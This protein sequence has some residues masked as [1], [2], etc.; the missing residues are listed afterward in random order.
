MGIRKE[1]MKDLFEAFRRVDQTKNRKIEGTGLGLPITKQLVEMMGGSIM[2]DS[3]YR[4]GSTFTIILEQKIIDAKPM[5]EKNFMVKKQKV[6]RE[7]YRQ[8]FEAPDAKVLVVD[9][10]E[11][12][13]MV[14][15]KLLRG[16]KVQVETAKSG[17]ECLLMTRNKHYHAILMDHVMPEMDG[18]ETM[19]RIRKQTNGQCNDTPIIALTANAM[20]GAEE[21]YQQMGFEGY[22]AKPISGVLLEATLLRYLP[23]ELV[24]YDVVEEEQEALLWQ[25]GKKKR[26]VVITTECSADIPKVWKD[27]LGIGVQTSYI[28]TAHGRFCDVDEVATENVLAYLNGGNKAYTEPASVEEF[29]KFFSDA[30][31]EAETVIHIS[32]SS[33][34]ATAYNNA[35]EAAKGFDNVHVIDSMHVSSGMG[36]EVLFA[37]QLAKEGKSAEYILEKLEELRHLV[38]TSFVVASTESL[39]L[40][41]RLSRRMHE[42]CDNLNVRPVIGVLQGKMKVCGIKIGSFEHAYKSYIRG[43][44][45]N[46]KRI[47]NRI[48]IITHAGCTVKQQ[49]LIAAEVKKYM[50]FDTV[51]FQKACATISSNCGLG[52]F[53]LLY[54]KKG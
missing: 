43:Q 35:V 39:Y 27:E 24:E 26:Q 34:I 4:K 20:S 25:N 10:N 53:G 22:L 29:E 11:M 30:L 54:M 19:Q 49:E 6:G 1:E 9:D 7:R 51:I 15:I 8:R 41:N 23:S 18:R 50:E 37:A 3:I 45:K 44:L 28:N 16:T 40:N 13:L 12:N 31:S 38:N 36:L 5:G 48:L 32:V 42:L 33:H 14:A 2:V 52:C 21:Q 17:A 46:K 47:D